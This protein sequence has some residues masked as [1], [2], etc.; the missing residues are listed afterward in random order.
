MSKRSIKAKALNSMINDNLCFDQMN[1]ESIF[2]NLELTL[3]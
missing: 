1:G 2:S 3:K